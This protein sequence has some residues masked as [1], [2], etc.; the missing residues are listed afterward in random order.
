MNLQVGH[1]ITAGSHKRF[2]K[3][4]LGAVCGVALV[5]GAL[6]GV[7]AWRVAGHNANSSEA[8]ASGLVSASAAGLMA[9]HTHPTFTYLLV[10]S[11]DE[12]DQVDAAQGSA[13]YFP[14]AELAEHE[15]VVISSPAEEEQVRSA[16]ADA[17][18]FAAAY[19][20]E[21]PKIA[22]L[23]PP[24]IGSTTA[25]TAIQPAQTGARTFY[26]VGSQEQ[27]DRTESAWAQGAYDGLAWELPFSI[28]VVNSPEDLAR[29]QGA[30]AE[31][32][33]AVIVDLRPKEGSPAAAANQAIGDDDIRFYLVGSQEQADEIASGRLN[34]GIPPEDAEIVRSGSTEEAKWALDG[35]SNI[36]VLDIVTSADEEAQARSSLATISQKRQTLGQSPVRILDLR[37]S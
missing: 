31:I 8:R 3:E 33:N 36:Q 12:A 24:A 29:V 1:S 28:A 32:D 6:A 9:G 21:G 34:Q 15:I 20:E 37:G 23:R 17:G 10:S 26:L 35:L 25:S 18:R 11:Q 22:D 13:G 27:A 2:G 14:G 30:A 19:G 7:G 5:A 4:A 16:V